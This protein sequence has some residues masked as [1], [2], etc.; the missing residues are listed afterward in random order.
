M[1]KK[2]SQEQSETK[3][4]IFTLEEENKVAYEYDLK[5]GIVARA[6]GTHFMMDRYVRELI[7]Q[8]IKV[9]KFLASIQR[10]F[11]QNMPPSR[12]ERLV[13]RNTKVET[14]FGKLRRNM[15]DADIQVI[16]SADAVSLW[17]A[18]RHFVAE[19]IEE[20]ATLALEAFGF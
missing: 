8:P 12:L 6:N 4:K 5:T 2:K 13:V 14:Q 11:K 3:K 15:R 17:C 20:A 7:K 10:F 18:G 19:D 9:E 1:A 16:D